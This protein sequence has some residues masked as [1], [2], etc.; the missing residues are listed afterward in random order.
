[1]S[2]LVSYPLDRKYL[3]EQT[4]SLLD[5]IDQNVSFKKGGWIAGGFPR[6]LAHNIFIKNKDD[7]EVVSYFNNSASVKIGSYIFSSTNGDIDIFSPKEV[8]IDDV[9]L[10]K[11]PQARSSYGS[12][13]KNLD[14]YSLRG[15]RSDEG[16][17]EIKIQFVDHE[18]MRYDNVKSCL[19]NF[20]LVNSKYALEKDKNTE[21]WILTYDMDA[22]VADT[23]KKISI[24]KNVSPFLG[25]RIL[26]Y[27]F[28]KGCDNGLT[29]ESREML[30]EWVIK[31]ACGS[32]EEHINEKHL[33]NLSKAVS[34]LFVLGLID[35]SLVPMFLGKWNESVT[36][37][38]YDPRYG[39]LMYGQARLVDWAKNAVETFEDTMK[40]LPTLKIKRRW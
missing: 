1:M 31:V 18:T 25:S 10:S 21:N 8:K 32:W 13:A 37:L 30:Q 17:P 36:D 19:E 20:D 2:K 27:Q 14:A 33:S 3:D 15:H 5:I 40:N 29:E 24:Q 22:F 26:K 4:I 23:N 7:E 9:F 35:V 11:S 28:F 34:I 39:E 16:R 6:F 38:E 12:Y